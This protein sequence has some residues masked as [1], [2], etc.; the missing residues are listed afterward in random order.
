MRVFITKMKTPLLLF[1]ASLCFAG[2]GFVVGANEEVYNNRIPALAP[3]TPY[4]IE[5]S[6]QNVTCNWHASTVHI[7]N[8]GAFVYC[9]SGNN[10]MYVGIIP[11]A[12]TGSAGPACS[13]PAPSFSG[14]VSGFA[15]FR[16]QHI[17]RAGGGGTDTCQ[18]WDINGTLLGSSTSSYTAE[19]N[20]YS[21]GA[22][23]G[24]E[25][26]VAG[27]VV[28]FFRV[29]ASTVGVASRPPITADSTD[30]SRVFEWKFDGNLN[31]SG[32]GK[33]T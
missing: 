4:R 5:M 29:Y 27:N 22:A 32:P 8:V 19:T 13:I 24:D 9:P 7:V 17:P 26:G 6:L 30:S 3:G 23:I 28:D 20:A 2:Q 18:G 25:W 31:D 15:T 11:N 1:A 16:F 33:Y 10:P 21:N 12:E 14:Y